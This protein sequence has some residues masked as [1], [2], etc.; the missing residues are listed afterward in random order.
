MKPH[1]QTTSAVSSI[2]GKY[3]AMTNR[4][5]FNAAFDGVTEPGVFSQTF[6]RNIR[7]ALASALAQDQTKGQK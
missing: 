5:M 3:L 2:A 4:Q 7:K 1:K 6:F